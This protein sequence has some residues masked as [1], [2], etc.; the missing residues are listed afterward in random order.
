MVEVHKTSPEDTSSAFKAELLAD[1]QRGPIIQNLSSNRVMITWQT[2]L[3]AD[4]S[5]R[6]GSANNL[7]GR[8][9]RAE[10]HTNHVMT[11]TDLVPATVYH[12]QIVN[13]AEDQVAAFWEFEPI[14]PAGPRP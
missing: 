2:P 4:A 11:L 9:V 6:Y 1:F 12:Y 3:P 14:P 8:V 7:T 5:V 10:L 13:Q